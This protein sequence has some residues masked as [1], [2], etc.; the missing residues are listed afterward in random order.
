MPDLFTRLMSAPVPVLI[1]NP[2]KAITIMVMTKDMPLSITFPIMPESLMALK[3][4]LV[5]ITNTIGGGWV[6]DYGNAPSPFTISGTF[7][8]NTK[9]EVGGKTY[10]GFGWTKYLEW[11]VDQSHE[12]DEDGA[13]PETWMLSWISQH[14][15]KIV[16]EDFNITQKY[17]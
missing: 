2:P 7:G 12:P 16:M 10:T 8:Y 1:D 5:T 15:Y 9:A 14:F 13:I 11:L 6:D 4:Y 17:Q 3:K